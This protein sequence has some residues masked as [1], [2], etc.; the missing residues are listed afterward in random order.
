MLKRYFL[1]IVVVLLLIAIAWGLYLIGKTENGNNKPIQA[2]IS[3][4][5][6]DATPVKLPTADNVDSIFF[7]IRNWATQSGNN[8]YKTEP[9]TT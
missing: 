9:V 8:I 7:P 6:G 3:Q 5:Q 1:Q 4:T 2:S